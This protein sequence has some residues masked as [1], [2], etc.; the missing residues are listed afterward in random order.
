MKNKYLKHI[1]TLL[2]VF[3]MTLIMAAVGISRNYG[4]Q[5]GWMYQVLNT[6]S[7][8]FPVAYVSAFIII[9]IAKKLTEKAAAKAARTFGRS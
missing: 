7:V 6:W 3:P 1:N 8:M 4:F 5:D 9:P 2:V